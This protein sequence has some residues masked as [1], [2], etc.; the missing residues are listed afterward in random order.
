VEQRLVFVYADAESA[1][2]VSE[3]FASKG[4]DVV[5]LSP[6]GQDCLESVAAAHPTAVVLDISE[7]WTDPLVVAQGILADERLSRPLLV[8]VGGSAES[9]SQC[10]ETLP[11]GVYVKP[12]ELAWVLT[13]L[14]LRL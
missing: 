8:F 11:F 3:P 6:N 13:R 9:V 4:I 14:G 1:D 7:D 10:K 2:R 5:V 12:E